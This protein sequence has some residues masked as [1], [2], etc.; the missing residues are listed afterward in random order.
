MHLYGSNT[1]ILFIVISVRTRNFTIIYT[2]GLGFARYI[3]M[4]FKCAA[5]EVVYLQS[6]IQSTCSQKMS[7]CR[8]RRVYLQS[9]NMSTCR[10]AGTSLQSPK[11]L[12]A[13]PDAV[14]LQSEVVCL[15][16]QKGLF[17]EQEYVHL[18]NLRH[19][20]SEPQVPTCRTGCCLPAESED[21]LQS[22]TQSSY[23]AR[24]SLRA[25]PKALPMARPDA[26]I[27]SYTNLDMDGDLK[28]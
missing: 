21:C 26:H 6:R 2:R 4:L 15:Q 5:S 16:S 1:D 20:P 10:A 18:K 28:D 17:V 9:R 12:P 25:E 24:N 14:Y 11:C 13:E 22:Q 23:I 8:A 19:L 3:V 27:L 7:A